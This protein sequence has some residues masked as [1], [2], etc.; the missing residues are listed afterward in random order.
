MHIQKVDN[1][2][3]NNEAFKINSKY[4]EEIGK[5][6]SRETLFIHFSTDYVFDGLKKNPY[7]TTD[8]ANPLNIYGKSKLGGEK[9]IQKL[10][11]NYIIIRT[12]AL[13]SSFG[14]NFVKKICELINNNNEIN[15]VN[16]QYFIPTP[17]ED[18]ANIIYKIILNHSKKN[19]YE[20]L[21]HFVGS[22]DS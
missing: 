16:D 18:L 19:I 13:F 22:G 6:I 3:N 4:I 21:F 10:M 1:A 17:C 11:H 8:K 9:F 5:I 15:V 12:S 2:E 20:D 7:L 14:A